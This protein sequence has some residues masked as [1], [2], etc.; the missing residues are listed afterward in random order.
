MEFIIN[1]FKLNFEKDD[2]D[3][4]RV[5]RAF[6]ELANKSR[7]EYIQSYE[8]CGTINKV[9]KDSVTDLKHIYKEVTDIVVVELNRRKVWGITPEIFTNKC[10]EQCSAFSDE[11]EKV[12]EAYLEITNQKKM[13]EAQR[14]AQKNARGR[15]VGGGFGLSGAIKGM[16]IAGTINTVAGTVNSVFDMMGNSSVNSSFDKKLKELY[17]NNSV[18]KALADAVYRDIVSM[19]GMF[20]GFLQTK[21]PSI[22]IKYNF[23][24]VIEAESIKQ[25]IYNGS[26]PDNDIEEALVDML[27]A[28][29]AMEESYYI[30]YK[31]CGT[32][33]GELLKLAEYFDIDIDLRSIEKGDNLLQQIFG[34]H[35][36][37][38]EHQFEYNEYFNSLKY[39][40]DESIEELVYKCIQFAKSRKLSSTYTS[41][42]F[43]FRDYNNQVHLNK[44][45]KS[46]AQYDDSETPLLFFDTTIFTNGSAGV[47]LT[48]KKI[49]S[50]KDKM[51]FNL[52]GIERVVSEG[53]YVRIDGVPIQEAYDRNDQAQMLDFLVQVIKHRK[54]LHNSNQ[55]SYEQ[56]K[57]MGID[58]VNEY[59]DNELQGKVIKK[60]ESELCKEIEEKFF[61]DFKR[62][63]AYNKGF[64]TNIRQSN[65]S[66]KILENAIKSYANLEKTEKILFWYDNT[67]TSSGKEGFVI[68]NKFI[69]YKNKYGQGRVSLHEINKVEYKMISL[70]PNY[71]INQQLIIPC[72]FLDHDR[73]KSFVEIFCNMRDYIV[74][75]S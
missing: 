53:F 28:F 1:N 20:Y 15:V 69:Y 34:N 49:Y 60:S 59:E 39:N 16:L 71:I 10:L 23:N 62:D 58:V 25:N 19:F 6:Y 30:T 52:E 64:F 65:D 44:A 41:S 55:E 75:N 50:S 22:K 54:R 24:N 47:L 13:V 63:S 38:L 21:Y 2:V 73:L 45:R 26:V 29:P 9:V 35:L 14:Q 61:T 33:N 18:K 51:T 37:K 32:S 66:K 8:K 56:N 57:S 5:L 74:I 72:R 7:S 40:I 31:I 12:Y 48:D 70:F 27:I 3:S 36:D 46:F 68:T 67:M 43:E 11:I 4:A 42:V 17:R